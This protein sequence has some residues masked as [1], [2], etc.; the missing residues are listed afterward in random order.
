MI[1]FSNKTSNG[2]FHY[3]NDELELV[4]D[5]NYSLNENNE[6]ISINLSFG[7]SNDTSGMVHG[8]L[9]GYG[10]ESNMSYNINVSGVSFA[11]LGKALTVYSDIVTSIKNNNSGESEDDEN[12]EQEN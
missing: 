3:T 6:L 10:N 2:S 11:I 7:D 12:S 4:I 1:T 9:N 8:S 5:G